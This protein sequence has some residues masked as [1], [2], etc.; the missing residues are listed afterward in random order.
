MSKQDIEYDIA[1][2]ESQLMFIHAQMQENLEK[3][4][5]FRTELKN[6]MEGSIDDE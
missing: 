4:A 6:F 5:E 2:I 3:I 1:E